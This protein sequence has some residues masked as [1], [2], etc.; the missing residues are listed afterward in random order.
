MDSTLKKMLNLMPPCTGFS[1]R[2]PFAA[3]VLLS[4]ISI[5]RRV[6]RAVGGLGTVTK[7]FFCK[8]ISIEERCLC[9]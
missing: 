9:V 4:P 5:P 3:L 8:A 2:L 7:G 1:P 6:G